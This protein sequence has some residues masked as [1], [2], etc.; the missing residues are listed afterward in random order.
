MYYKKIDLTKL[1]SKEL[2]N[3]E[4][5]LKI[6][7]S[8]KNSKIINF[9]KSF[10]KNTKLYHILENAKNGSLFFYINSK[11]GL[12]PYL[13]LKFFKSCCLAIS[14]LHSQNILHRDIKP[15][16]I[17]IDESFG[18]K[19]CDFGWS[20][21][22]SDKKRLDEICGT[23][24]YMPLEIF[25]FIKQSEKFDIWQLGVLLYEMI[26]GNPFFDCNDF[27]MMKNKLLNYDIFFDDKKNL[28]IERIFLCEG[29]NKR[30][31]SDL[32]RSR[33]KNVNDFLRFILK[34][35]Y[36]KRPTIEE[37]LRHEIWD[38][39][40]FEREL[41][42]GEKNE[43]RKNYFINSQFLKNRVI[44]DFIKK[45]DFEDLKNF[46]EISKNGNFGKNENIL[47]NGKNLNFINLD[48]KSKRSFSNFVNKKKI[49]EKIINKNFF[50]F[51]KKNQNFSNF[52]IEK[53]N[54]K[55]ISSN[56]VKKNFVRKNFFLKNEKKI[57]S[58][59][60]SI[61]K[62]IPYN[63]KNYD[64]K[65]KNENYS[66]K[67]VYYKKRENSIFKNLSKNQNFV[68]IEKKNNLILKNEKFEKKKNNFFFET[69][70]YIPSRINSNSFKNFKNQK[71]NFPKKKIIYLSPKNKIF[72]NH[73][74]SKRNFS[75]SK[76]STK[77][78][79]FY[80][81]DFKKK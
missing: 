52:K 72:E 58:Q 36:R 6:H 21:F 56:F 24:E 9:E 1:S 26:Y 27:Y 29:L 54:N 2:I 3:L 66:V 46:S 8:I 7:R 53:Q 73:R 15:E 63:F 71:N 77:N 25:E 65:N 32:K 47:K 12:N 41:S 31:T 14:H 69:K 11:K 75:L 5:E 19:I 38:G 68:K 50:G 23:I 55:F 49:N 60:N 43:M 61:E 42:F 79:S 34:K 74:K 76:F 30:L 35:D 22:L 37:I 48:N 33:G 70:K 28:E 80:D 78:V 4:L 62:K 44:P 81:F 67:K 13:S 40:D 10:K 20:V 17:L 64:N 45:M 16:N 57:K 51:E 39:F 18:I 59:N